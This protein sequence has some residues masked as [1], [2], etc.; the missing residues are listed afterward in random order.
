[1]STYYLISYDVDY[2]L[3]P[4]SNGGGALIHAK[5]DSVANISQIIS[6]FLDNPELVKDIFFDNYPKDDYPSRFNFRSEIQNYNW[7]K[8]RAD[9]EYY[10]ENPND[11]VTDLENNDSLDQY[12]LIK[13][14]SVQNLNLAMF[15]HYIKSA[16]SDGIYLNKKHQI[17]HKFGS[18]N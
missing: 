16:S 9:L 12:L 18:N 3:E 1:M 5:F 6:Y 10:L 7:N 8:I 17:V 4:S 14:D 11:F 13:A 15:N 2:L